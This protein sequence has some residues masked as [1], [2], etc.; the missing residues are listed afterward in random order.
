MF[1]NNN[2]FI[3]FWYQKADQLSTQDQRVLTSD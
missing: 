1:N 2:I 3:L